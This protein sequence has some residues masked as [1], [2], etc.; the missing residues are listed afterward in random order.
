M[1]SNFCTVCSLTLG[2]STLEDFLKLGCKDFVRL[3][4]F[5]HPYLVGDQWLATIKPQFHINSGF[6]SSTHKS[7]A[8]Y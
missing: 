3:F 5:K 7:F 1:R 4:L 8:F 6:S 2:Q